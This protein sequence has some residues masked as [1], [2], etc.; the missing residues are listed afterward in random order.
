MIRR[1]RPVSVAAPARIVDAS[2][3][4]VAVPAGGVLR[5]IPE[6]RLE[7]PPVRL[8]RSKGQGAVGLPGANGCGIGGKLVVSTS[9]YV[10]SEYG[11]DSGSGTESSPYRSLWKVRKL[12]ASGT[13]ARVTVY[14]REGRTW[15]LE[16]ELAAKGLTVEE[17]ERFRAGG[18]F[19]GGDLSLFAMGQ[20]TFLSTFLAK[21]GIEDISDYFL[22]IGASGSAIYPLRIT[23]YWS[24]KVVNDPGTQGLRPVLDGQ[25]GSWDDLHYGVLLNQVC[26]VEISGVEIRAF[27]EGVTVFGACRRIELSDLSVHDHARTGIALRP[28]IYVD[29][30]DAE[31]ADPFDGC[32]GPSKFELAKPTQDEGETDDEYAKRLAD[33]WAGHLGDCDE[34]DV[35]A[36]EEVQILDCEV[37]DNGLLTDGAN[38]VFG[39]CVADCTVQGN[40]IYA[41]RTG[42]G[43]DGLTLDSSRSGHIIACN[44]FAHHAANVGEGS[45]GDGV[46]LKGVRPRAGDDPDTVTVVRD[47]VIMDNRGVGILFHNGCQGIHV[48]NNQIWR[49]GVGI[50]M[51]ANTIISAGESWQE[52]PEDYDPA[53]NDPVLF[54]SDGNE[55]DWAC[56]PLF[57]QKDI[58]IYRN[59]IAQ[60]TEEGIRLKN[61][62]F[63]TWWSGSS[64]GDTDAAALRTIYR[65]FWI[66]HNTIDSNGKE[67]ISILKTPAEDPRNPRLFVREIYIKNNIITRNARRI[68]KES[69]TYFSYR[70]YIQVSIFELGDGFAGIDRKYFLDSPYDYYLDSKSDAVY[71]ARYDE[72]ATI[73]I[74]GN[75]YWSQ[76]PYSYINDAERNHWIKNDDPDCPDAVA[77]DAYQFTTYQSA[78]IDGTLYYERY[79]A[80][81]LSAAEVQVAS[82]PAMPAAPNYWGLSSEASWADP[83]SNCGSVSFGDDSLIAPDLRIDFSSRV[84]FIAPAT[85]GLIH[86]ETGLDVTQSMDIDR[87]APM[88]L[89]PSIGAYQVLLL[90][91]S[92]VVSDCERPELDG[93]WSGQGLEAS[94]EHLSS[95]RG[96]WREDG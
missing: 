89:P 82:P 34:L 61:D 85:T 68:A 72:V 79:A 22:S 71:I 59:V 78:D 14:L 6:S 57:A 91:S 54:D 93:S 47:N 92:K 81:R 86:L 2:G 83:M 44:W 23:S 49:N 84:T 88:G 30:T 16:S 42:K 40:R 21:N 90:G 60:S 66:V 50:V 87:Y 10:D 45:D 37:F 32:S 76:L 64:E 39:R 27:H 62:G 8:L 94:W 35:P 77:T 9:V 53:T 20:A 7:G 19:T 70:S 63:E 17:W 52:R 25:L 55:I 12:L 95:T 18:T 48:Y 31:R 73:V 41:T 36:P 75:A 33:D 4:L 96:P 74:D 1:G 15:S 28:G 43:V 11:D 3:R 65:N 24:D 56:D 67:G 69:G 80:R 38:I 26:H 5:A 29:S 58:F 46:D 51:V 13:A